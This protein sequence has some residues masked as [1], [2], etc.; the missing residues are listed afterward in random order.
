M[1][2]ITVRDLSHRSKEVVDALVAGES[3]ALKKR[4]RIIATISPR[5]SAPWPDR[6]KRM[7]RIFGQKSFDI[8]SPSELLLKDRDRP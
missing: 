5:P 6:L 4:N 7:K 2:T 1:K 8:P 3:F